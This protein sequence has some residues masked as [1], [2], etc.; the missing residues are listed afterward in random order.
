[1]IKIS[2]LL[3]I[4]IQKVGVVLSGTMSHVTIGDAQCSKGRVEDIDYRN[5]SKYSA[6]RLM[7]SRIIES[8][9]YCNQISLVQ[10]YRNRAQSTSVN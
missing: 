6:R 1:M 3:N 10:V 7:G 8:A 4:Y 2:L 9:A 5:V